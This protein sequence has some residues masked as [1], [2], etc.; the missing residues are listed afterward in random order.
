MQTADDRR[1]RLKAIRDQAS[2]FKEETDAGAGALLNPLA[3]G[4]EPASS[5]TPAESFSFYS[6]P[7]AGL[8]RPDH[9]QREH[10]AVQEGAVVVASK[11]G[12]VQDPCR[13]AATQ[14]GLREVARARL[15]GQAAN[16]EP[17]LKVAVK[18]GGASL[19]SLLAGAMQDVAAAEADKSNDKFTEEAI[20]DR[21]WH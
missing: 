2:Q 13:G 17:P 4:A 10:M 9:L 12:G 11:L 8:V 3:D 5:S 16:T 18:Q 20:S 15:A 14:A 6:D 21:P 1:K 19:A 7:L